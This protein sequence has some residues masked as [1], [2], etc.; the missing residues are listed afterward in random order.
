VVQKE[1]DK[2]PAMR[3]T[4][5]HG[6]FTQVSAFRG[7]GVGPKSNEMI[8]VGE[9]IDLGAISG[10]GTEKQHQGDS[11]KNTTKLVGTGRKKGRKVDKK[12]R[13]RYMTTRDARVPWEKKRNAT[14]RGE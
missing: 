14:T 7:G 8:P 9:K 13:K 6:G 11:C 5:C 12:K 3:K 2:A 4:G 10:N 1:K